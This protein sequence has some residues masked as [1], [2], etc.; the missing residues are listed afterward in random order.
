VLAQAS[1]PQARS[2]LDLAT[3]WIYAL[4]RGDLRVL[5]NASTYPFEL[6]IQNA[7]C[8][9]EG[10]KARDKNELAALL[11]ELS[12]SED[13]KALEVTSADVKEIFRDKLPDWAKPWS[14]RLPK[15]T[16]LV[17]IGSSGAGTYAITYVLLMKNDQVFA[18]WLNATPG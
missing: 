8:K 5:D 17:H 16:R 13:V 11:G 18:V 6:R 10:G 2:A 3:S 12:K 1:T 15:G 7:P 9:C 4:K 14:K